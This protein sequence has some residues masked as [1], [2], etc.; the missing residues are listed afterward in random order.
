MPWQRVVAFTGRE[1]LS[2]TA[3][4]VCLP[5]RERL[6]VLEMREGG[7]PCYWEERLPFLERS[8][9]VL[10]GRN[11]CPEKQELPILEENFLSCER[12]VACPRCEDWSVLGM[13]KGLSARG[14]LVLGA[15]SGL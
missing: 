10:R 8:V 9:F 5:S 7:L 4:L 11:Y 15:R 6:P 13:S 3:A 1:R 12:G 14:L 2:E